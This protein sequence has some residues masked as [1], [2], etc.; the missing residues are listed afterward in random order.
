MQL[1]WWWH[2]NAQDKP[3]Y[4]SPTTN[5]SFIKIPHSSGHHIEQFP[6]KLPHPYP[7]A[8]TGDGGNTCRGLVFPDTPARST[9]RGTMTTWRLDR[10]FFHVLTLICQTESF[11]IVQIP[12]VTSLLIIIL[13]TITSHHTCCFD[14]GLNSLECLMM[15]ARFSPFSLY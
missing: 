13:L 5:M 6:W 8:N 1:L 7:P 12:S 3:L 9:I 15:L 11:C 14:C 2:S 10:D 4:P